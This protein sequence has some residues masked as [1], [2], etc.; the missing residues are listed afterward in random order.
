MTLDA[1]N[2]EQASATVSPSD[3]LV[4][5][6][7]PGTGKTMTMACRLAWYLTHGVDPK[8][9]LALTFTV[10]A[11]QELSDRVAA[12][13]PRGSEVP[14]RT[15]HSHALTLIRANPNAFGLLR[16]FS[17]IDEDDAK[18]LW[19]KAFQAAL[20]IIARDDDGVV[21]KPEGFT[22]G[23]LWDCLSYSRNAC[24]PLDQF[25]HARF[26]SE[27]NYAQHI[28]INAWPLYRESKLAR[29][30]IDFDD[31]LV[32]WRDRLEREPSFADSLRRD[33]PIL[34]I[35][36][37]QDTNPLQCAILRAWKPSQ[38]TVVGDAAQSIFGFRGSRSAILNAAAKHPSADVIALTTSYRSTRTIVDVVNRVPRSRYAVTTSIIPADSAQ[39]GEPP[40]LVIAPN[41]TKE[42][43]MAGAWVARYLHDHP[44]A[45]VAILSRVNHGLLRVE[46][47]LIQQGLPYTLWGGNSITSY[48]E[49]KDALACVR[50]ATNPKDD[51]ALTRLLLLI[52]GIGPSTAQ[53]IVEGRATVPHEALW[54]MKLSGKLDLTD[55]VQPFL[56]SVLENLLPLFPAHYRADAPARTERLQRLVDNLKPSTSVSAFLDAMSLD[57]GDAESPLHAP[58]ITLATIHAAKGREWDAVWVIGVGA[59]QLPHPSAATSVDFEEERNLVYVALSRARSRLALSYPMFTQTGQRQG[60]SRLLPKGL[61]WFKR[62]PKQ[63]PVP[64]SV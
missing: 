58:Q 54:I 43:E 64:A 14:V 32:L 44:E 51:L 50:F 12:C 53:A 4:V 57:Q 23:D 7:G 24:Q 36:E 25:I 1:L 37:Y 59:R 42:A 49:A 41:A 60:P 20:D 6:A 26:P 21:V 27:A 22:P 61:P 18:T 47:F 13:H 19:E 29:N 15:F 40:H 2:R 45:T 38:L 3:R 33:C 56:V 28:L 62:R 63:V 16:S 31:L 34:L 11:A 52:P 35:D 8:K 17:I 5:V 9:M 48:A 46:P 39:D 10:R 30:A 55:P